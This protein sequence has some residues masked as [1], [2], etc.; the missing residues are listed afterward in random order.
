MI[1]F[2]ELNKTY[3]NSI[4]ALDDINLSIED[5]EFTFITGPSGAGKSTLVRLLIREEKPNHGQIMFDD[6]DV[7]NLPKKFLPEYRQQIGVS[8][9]DLKLIESR[10]AQ[11]N[12]EFALE[13]I[14]KHPREIKEIAEYLLDLVD[15]KERA[16]LSPLCLSGGEKQKI[17]IAR[18]LASEPKVLIADE[19]TGNLDP[20]STGEILDILKNINET[21]TTVLVITHD[22]TI[23]NNLDTRVITLEEGKV[24]SDRIGGYNYKKNKKGG[25]KETTKK[26]DKK[27]AG[28]DKTKKQ[29]EDKKENRTKKTRTSSKKKKE[30]EKTEIEMLELPKELEEKLLY[31]EIDELEKLLDLTE[32]Q[33]KKKGLNENDLEEITNK[34]QEL[35][36]LEEDEENGS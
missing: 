2:K 7:V 28:G 11:E 13:I 21:D 1:D 6:I 5:S 9:Q 24:V 36:N 23:V 15:L 30:K 35:N 33:L 32:S 22:E 3:L 18:A 20:K 26:G 10:T 27:K 17:A 29:D 16:K 12:I 14:N 8:F 19:P 4:I 25:G 31:N 34:I